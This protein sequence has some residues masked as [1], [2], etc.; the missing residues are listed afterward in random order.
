[1]SVGWMK[2]D[3]GQ[4]GSAAQRIGSECPGVDRWAV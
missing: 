1:M 2:I 3:L 4:R